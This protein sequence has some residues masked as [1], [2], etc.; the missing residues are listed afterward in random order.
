M[1]FRFCARYVL[2]TYAQC[3][4]LSEWDVLDHISS[5]GAECIIGREDHADGG[6][7]LHAFCD[8]GKRKESRRADFF[9]VGGYHPNI[10]PSKGNP[11]GGWDYPC[12]E[13]NIVA[14]G[15]AR[16]GTD[17]M[18]ADSQRT[19]LAGHG[20]KWAQ[21]V[22]AEDR[23]TFFDL[24]R[25][26]D[27]KT[28]VTRWSE[29]NKYADSAYA[30]RPEPYKSPL[31]VDFDLGRAPDLAQWREENLGAAQQIGM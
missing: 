29:L 12:K 10:S 23:E 25:E 15:L 26:L 18:G 30:Q 17:D 27:P 19:R 22:A 7:H 8:F 6:T 21:I 13:G 24:L 11:G 2:L 14:G 28:L 31:S 5:L 20:A 4:N 9:D 3:G 16:P 1:S